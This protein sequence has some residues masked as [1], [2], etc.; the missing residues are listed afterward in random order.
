MTLEWT[1]D[2]NNMRL[3][4]GSH[5]SLLPPYWLACFTMSMLVC[6]RDN[7]EKFYR[8][9]GI[10]GYKILNVDIFIIFNRSFFFY[11]CFFP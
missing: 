10:N 9:E 2:H 6:S 7:N 4:N 5:I 11:T 3:R 8:H 1:W